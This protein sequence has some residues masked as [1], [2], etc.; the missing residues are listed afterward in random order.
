MIELRKLNFENLDTAADEA[1]S[2]LNTG[3]EQKGKWTLGQ[4]CN[5]LCRV[6]DPSVG[7]YP[8]WLSLFAFMRPLMRKIFLP[9]LMRG[10]SPRGIPTAPNFVPPKQVED[11]A[12]VAKFRES[13]ARFKAHEGRY[14][15][16][17]AFGRMNR[18][19]LEKIHAAHAAHHFRFLQPPP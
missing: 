16:H 10:D 5:H 4:I 17:P 3:Y 2:L 1:R 6:Q 19:D 7:G 13:V 11:A 8:A 12:E 15:P 14:A 18:D 9:R